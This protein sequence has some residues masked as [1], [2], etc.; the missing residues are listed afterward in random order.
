MIQMSTKI[1]FKYI[2]RQINDPKIRTEAFNNML[3]ILKEY[4]I[5]NKK[6]ITF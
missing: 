4:K 1:P 2:D 5:D 3:S 6:S